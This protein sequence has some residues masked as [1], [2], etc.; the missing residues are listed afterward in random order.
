MQ[1]GW[2]CPAEPYLETNSHA[3]SSRYPTHSRRVQKLKAGKRLRLGAKREKPRLL[4]GQGLRWIP[5]RHLKS[6]ASPTVSQL[7]S[8]DVGK[9]RRRLHSDLI[10]VCFGPLCGLKSAISRGPRSAN[11][12]KLA[13]LDHLVSTGEKRG[14]PSR[15]I[16]TET[17]TVDQLDQ[18]YKCSRRNPGKCPDTRRIVF[19][20]RTAV[21]IS[22]TTG[23]YARFRPPIFGNLQLPK[24]LILDR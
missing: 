8:R 11:K 6:P 23:I 18:H 4:Q 7:G 20:S 17:Q 1:G 15:S 19:A 5:V 10:N 22:R 9:F 24:Q 21:A 3:P 2:V 14:H 13:L 16:T 12:R